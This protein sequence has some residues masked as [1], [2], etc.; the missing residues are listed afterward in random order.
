MSKSF[1]ELFI[2]VV[3]KLISTTILYLI[4]NIFY[5]AGEPI[6]LQSL[7]CGPFE[8]VHYIF[9]SHCLAFAVTLIRESFSV[10]WVGIGF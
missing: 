8:V 7:R 10:G 5:P 1:S 2:K 9:R 4:G 6:S 3:A